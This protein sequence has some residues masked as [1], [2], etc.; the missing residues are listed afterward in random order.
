[1]L[2]PRSGIRSVATNA[3]RVQKVRSTETRVKRLRCYAPLYVT[4]WLFSTDLMP[5][6][7]YGTLG[8]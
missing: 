8:N 7:G 3:K 5:L 2:W 4:L 1:M 6:R